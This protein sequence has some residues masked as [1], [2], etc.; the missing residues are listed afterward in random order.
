MIVLRQ[1]V[2]YAIVGLSSNAV[3][4]AIY[5]LQTQV[6][7]G[8]KLAA[9]IVYGLGV[10]ATFVFN[11]RWTFNDEGLVGPSFRRYVSAYAIGYVVNLGGLMVLVDWRGYPHQL[12]EGVMIL[13]VAVLLFALQKWWVFQGRRAPLSAPAKA[14][15]AK[16]GCGE[17]PIQ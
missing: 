11:R 13:T 6:G 15:F 1:L 14:E 10:L 7:L 17:Y 3:L 12:V 4:Y 9:S 2:R 16:D 8:H 5:L